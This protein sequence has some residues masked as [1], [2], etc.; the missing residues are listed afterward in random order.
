MQRSECVGYFFFK[1]DADDRFSTIDSAYRSILTQVLL[2]SQGSDRAIIDLFLIAKYNKNISSGQPTASSKDLRN[3]S[4]SCALALGSLRL[5]ID[6]IDE[7]T[8]PGTVCLQLKR[9]IYSAPVKL[10]CVSRT[11]VDCLLNHMPLKQRILVDRNS[12]KDDIHIYLSRQLADLDDD[13]KL[14]PGTNLDALSSQMVYSADGMF[15]WAKLMIRFIRFPVFS[16]S[17]R[18]KFLQSLHSPEGLDVMY[19]RILHTI[20]NAAKPERELASTIFTWI[21]HVKSACTIE[22]L[23]GGIQSDEDSEPSDDLPSVAV[24]VCAGLI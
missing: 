1:Q 21:Y 17:S 23:Q 15:F 8:D 20:N 14:P 3:L 10:L 19:S 16:P 7:A 6:G 18:L 13:G 4:T 5:A 22:I 9:L 11:N 12:V 24:S 2:W